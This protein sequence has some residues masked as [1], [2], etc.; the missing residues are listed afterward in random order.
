MCLYGPWRKLKQFS[1]CCDICVA[2]GE[3]SGHWGSTL[4]QQQWHK[5]ST[6]SGDVV[7]PRAVS[8]NQSTTIDIPRMRECCQESRLASPASFRI[9]GKGGMRLQERTWS[10][11][12]RG[13]RWKHR[14][15]VATWFLPLFLMRAL[16]FLYQ[17]PSSF[18]SFLFLLPCV[19]TSPVPSHS[20]L[21]R[22]GCSSPVTAWTKG[23]EVYRGW[24]S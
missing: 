1:T 15:N 5:M 18:Y 12:Q 10:K 2:R 23:I 17:P 14:G 11:A 6:S 21:S 8:P 13:S 9:W 7:A 24:K 16:L 4:C 22:V 3:I 19:P 20:S